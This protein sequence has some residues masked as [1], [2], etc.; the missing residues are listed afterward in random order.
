MRRIRFGRRRRGS[1][2]P[3]TGFLSEIPKQV[4]KKLPVM[5]ETDRQGRLVGLVV[6]K[7]AGR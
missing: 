2:P 3:F 5:A 4:L 1:E 6:F 7:P